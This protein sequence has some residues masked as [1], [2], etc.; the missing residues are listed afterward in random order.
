M[1]PMARPSAIIGAART[2]HTPARKL[3]VDRG[4][5][6][7]LSS[8][9]STLMAHPPCWIVFVCSSSTIRHLSHS[10]RTPLSIISR[11]NESLISLFVGCLI[12]LTR[13]SDVLTGAKE[14]CYKSPVIRVIGQT[15]RELKRLGGNHVETDVHKTCQGARIRVC[16]RG[17]DHI[18][19]VFERR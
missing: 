8:T 9:S 12:R 17:N 11:K 1:I 2:D 16:A 14:T 18:D 3:E 7:M 15:R 10:L 19:G 6:F 4:N 5:S 13:F